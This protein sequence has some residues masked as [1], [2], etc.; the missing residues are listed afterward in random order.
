MQNLSTGQR[1]KLQFT[2]IKGI[3][4]T[5]KLQLKVITS[6]ETRIFVPPI[7]VKNKKGGI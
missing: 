3:P 4:K 2:V 7:R 1:L 5:R 6:V